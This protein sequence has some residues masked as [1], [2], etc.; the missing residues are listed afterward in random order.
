MFS[1][2]EM[3]RRRHR[4]GA[5]EVAAI[6]G[7]SPYQTPWEVWAEKTGLL[8]PFEGNR[9][10]QLGQRI[11]PALLDD[12]EAVYGPIE[13]QVRIDL[14]G[15]PISATLD[16]RLVNDGT[17]VECKTTGLAGPIAGHWGDS[18]TDHIPDHYALQCHT[19]MMCAD[20]DCAIVVALIPGR[21]I[22]HYR[23]ERDKEVESVL[24]DQLCFWWHN[25]IEL[26]IAPEINELPRRSTISRIVRDEAKRILLGDDAAHLLRQIEVLRTQRN[27][28]D[29]MIDKLESQ[30]LMSLGNA[31]IGELPDGREVTYMLQRRKSYV[32]SEKIFRVFRIRGKK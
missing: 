31:E 26:G 3:E 5:S 22:V 13:R 27:V 30:L 11:E 2:E 32:V 6:L 7:L 4:I 9:S 17:P 28:T 20:A 15:T 12:A 8:L 10:T 24:R 23:I 18:G 29:E 21:G 16:G 1:A 14:P 19:Q 25:H